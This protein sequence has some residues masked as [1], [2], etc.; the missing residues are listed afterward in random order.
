LSFLSAGFLK[1]PQ[2]QVGGGFSRRAPAEA[3]AYKKRK[4]LRPE[5]RR[6]EDFF[7]VCERLYSKPR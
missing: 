2:Q 4:S 5:P 1:S 7:V 3:G 6:I